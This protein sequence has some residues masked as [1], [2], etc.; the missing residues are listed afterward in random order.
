M[1][2]PEILRAESLLP[3]NNFL[4]SSEALI[5]QRKALILRLCTWNVL[6]QRQIYD[7][8]ASDIAKNHEHRKMLFR[9][10]IKKLNPDILCLQEVSYAFI[11]Q[12]P[13]LS[14]LYEIVVKMDKKSAKKIVKNSDYLDSTCATLVKKSLWSHGDAELRSTAIQRS[15]ETPLRVDSTESQETEPL[16]TPRSI[17][18]ATHSSRV[19]T[20]TIK[21]NGFEVVI[22]NVH[23]NAKNTDN[24]HLKHLIPLVTKDKIDIIIGDFNEDR[25]DTSGLKYLQENGYVVHKPPT[26]TY[27]RGSAKTL[28]YIVSKTS[29]GCEICPSFYTPGLKDDFPSD[30]SPVVAQITM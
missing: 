20:T 26:P 2:I 11:K 27:F 3:R 24:I 19:L 6:S 12:F 25:D 17:I 13:E 15:H 9:D 29:I 10:V 4:R 18:H 22:S 23:L 28:D 8:D 16:E 14:E 1:S 7:Y 30:H 21:I 5:D